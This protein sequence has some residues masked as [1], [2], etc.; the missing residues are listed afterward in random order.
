MD[1]DII[2]ILVSTDN[3]L[4]V[5]EKDPIRADDS[6]AAFEEVLITAKKKKADFVLLGG[7]TFHENKPSRRATHAAVSLLSKYCLGDDPIYVEV[8]NNQEEV[9]KSGEGKVNY[10]NPFLSIGLPV[11]A[12]H[13]NHVSSGLYCLLLSS[14]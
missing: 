12:I 3:H 2:R 4:G 5:F 9:F 1:D 6:Y 7:D 8:M 13:G 11:F 10:D 14:T